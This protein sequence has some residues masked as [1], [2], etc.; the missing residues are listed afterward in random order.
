MATNETALSGIQVRVRLPDGKTEQLV[1]DS[2]RVLIGSGSHCEVRLPAEH[3]AVEH[4]VVSMNPGGGGL[5]AAARALDRLP[6]LGGIEFAQT[7]LPPDTPIGVGKCEV[8]VTVAQIDANANVVKK[9]TQKNSPVTY[10]LAILAIPLAAFVLL[11]DDNGDPPAPIPKE[12]PVLFAKKVEKC[13][14]ADADQAAS[15]ALEKKVLAEAKRERRPFKV[16]D[17]I[18]AVPLFE[19]AG[20]CFAAAGNDD[21]STEMYEAGA[22]LKKTIESEYRAHQVRLEHALAVEDNL[23][24]QKE[25]RV[26]KA[27]TDGQA[28]KYVEWLGNT[29]RRLA[30]KLGRKQ[31]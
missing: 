16:Q 12:V 23:T 31:S 6:T 17:G 21:Q 8:W 29:E 15:L 18:A 1:I 19:T 5:H 3:A 14:V 9:K 4:V 10:V 7:P 2:D 11:Y 28:G 13:G 27:Y 20:A 25:V 24:A 26:L 30:L 22:A